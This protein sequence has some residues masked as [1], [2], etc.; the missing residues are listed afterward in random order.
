MVS[1]L[2]R[3]PLASYFILA[4][5]FAWILIPLVANVSVAFGLLALFAPALAAVVVTAALDGWT[6]ARRLMRDAFRPRGSLIWY[7]VAIALPFVLAGI[8]NV[9]SRMTGATPPAFNASVLPISMVLAVLVIGEE[10][11]WR[12][13]A[14]PRLQAIAHPLVAAIAL[15]VIWAAWHLPNAMIPGLEH[16]V[17]AFPAFLAYV[18]AITVLFSWLY[19][20]ARGSILVAWVFHGAI[21]TALAVFALDDIVDQFTFNAL[22]FGGAALL[23]VIATRGSLRTGRSR[24]PADRDGGVSS[25]ST[26]AS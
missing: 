15:G 17:T 25:I 9:V 12:G 11:G 24:Q 5:A 8:T 16:Y 14:L 4:Y 7:V 6:G 23:V 1:V 10:L 13:F 26:P 18:V 20:S 22:V 2:R 21:N 3:W 19:N